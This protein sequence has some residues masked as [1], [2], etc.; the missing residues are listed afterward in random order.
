ML[1]NEADNNETRKVQAM[2]VGTLYKLLD[3]LPERCDDFVVRF[4]LFDRTNW[5]QPECWY[6]DDD[7]DLILT[8]WGRD[9]DDDSDY[10]DYTVSSLKDLLDGGEDDAEDSVESW[11]KVYV[12][13]K[14]YDEDGDEDDTWYDILDNRCFINWKRER[15]DAL[16]EYT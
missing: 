6:I 12:M 1:T 3:R 7:G 11:Q 9:G 2:T 10:N 4:T 14:D 5:I 15:V 8:I 13:D 16:M